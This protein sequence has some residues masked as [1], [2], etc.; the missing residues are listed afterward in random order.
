MLSVIIITKN[1]AHNIERCLK[2]VAWAEE[3]IIV[4]SG[5]TDN[6]LEIAQQ[7]TSHVYSADWRGY[8]VQK[9]RALE[10]ATGDWVLNLDADESVSSDLKDAIVEAM[11]SSAA[12]AYRVPI[13]MKFYGQLLKYSSSPKRHVRLFK[14]EGA[15]F[16]NDVVH[17]KIILPRN[18]RIGKLTECIV[19]QSFQD[20]RH[21]LLKMNQYS[22]YTAKARLKAK[23]Q[24]SLLMAI[25]AAG[26]MFFRCFVLQRGFLDGQA[27][28]VL[29]VL[30]MEG[31]F[32][33]AMKQVYP[34]R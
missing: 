32:Y 19:H 26:W 15:K 6:T 30:N 3:V 20:L 4:D 24:S 31:A 22:S 14:R 34:D 13:R 17:E 11:A 23:G 10:Y 25:V 28:F 12:D 18:A 7:Y 21:A 2:S 8:G 1:E 9:Q 27:G 29:A 5:S 16:S 33:R